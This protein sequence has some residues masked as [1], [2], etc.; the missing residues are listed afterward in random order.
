MTFFY[1]VGIVCGGLI[2]AG[3]VIQYT[4]AFLWGRA[5]EPIVHRMDALQYAEAEDRA[6]SQ[7]RDSLIVEQVAQI[8]DAMRYPIGS[9][10]RARALRQSNSAPSMVRRSRSYPP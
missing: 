1:R 8:S 10:Q 4:G 7:R 6:A 9:T 2:A 5:T 3:T